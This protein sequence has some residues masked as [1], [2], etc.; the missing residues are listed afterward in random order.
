MF[1]FYFFD[2][3]IQ[4]CLHFQDTKSAPNW[5]LRNW[6]KTILFMAKT[7]LPALKESQLLIDFMSWN[8]MDAQKRVSYLLTKNVEITG[9]HPLWTFFTT[10]FNDTAALDPR[11][12]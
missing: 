8:N 10:G 3:F 2:V 4:F 6:I 12:W 1:A 7:S 5:S 11:N 9:W